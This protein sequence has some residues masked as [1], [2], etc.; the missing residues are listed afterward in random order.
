[1]DYNLVLLDLFR[2]KKLQNVGFL[3]DR[4]NFFPGARLLL[5]FEPVGLSEVDLVEPV[6]LEEEEEEGEV[7]SKGEPTLTQKEA[8]EEIVEAQGWI[9]NDRGILELVAHKTDLN[10]S[11]PRPKDARICNQ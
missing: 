7:V 9:I 4:S 8:E 6:N 5:Y 10:G 3:R 1:M 2:E 11:P